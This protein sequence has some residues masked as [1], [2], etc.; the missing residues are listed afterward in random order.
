[1]QLEARTETVLQLVTRVPIVNE[2]SLARL[3]I[4]WNFWAVSGSMLES[5]C[6]ESYR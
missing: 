4:S 5:L 6:D 1:M 2:R 3:G